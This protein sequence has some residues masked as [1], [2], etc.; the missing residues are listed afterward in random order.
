MFKFK[1][2]SIALENISV[3]L[4]KFSHDIHVAKILKVKSC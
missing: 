4:E 1:V 2:Y 3:Y